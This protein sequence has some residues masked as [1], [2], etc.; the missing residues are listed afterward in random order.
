[1]TMH[2][3]ILT[4]DILTD[5]TQDNP[6]DILF[7]DEL[8]ESMGEIAILDNLISRRLTEDIDNE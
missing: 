8:A 5:D 2:S 7:L 3:S 6:S 4:D 1:M